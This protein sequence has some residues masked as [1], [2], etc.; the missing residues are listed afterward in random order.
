M[1]VFILAAG[2]GTRLKPITDT[3]PKALVEINGIPLLEILL[4]RL[5]KYSPGN[6]VINI[7]HF[8]NQ[9]IEFLESRDNFG[10]NITI[11][12]ERSLLLDT[13]GGL[14]KATVLLKEEN[15]L[16]HNVDIISNL[17]LT[18]FMDYHT[19]SR[20][21]ATLAVQKRNSSRYFLFDEKTM[22]CGWE[23]IKTGEKIIT[24]NPQGALNRYAFSGIHAGSRNLFALMPD[25]D[26]FSIVEFY[27]SIAKS[28]QI[29]YF[30]HSE[31]RFIDLGKIDNLAE[32]E[33]IIKLL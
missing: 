15:F 3:V 21:I 6:I 1:E 22:L 11:S 32:A 25:K 19:N 23:N 10:L 16:I 8:G 17:N 7:H 4:K 9:I 31:T 27:L 12:D 5:S 13:G 14:K 24:R 26:I 30:D 33:N 29:T 28:H 2:L 18:S 20:C